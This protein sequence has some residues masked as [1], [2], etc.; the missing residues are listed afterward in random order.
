VKAF[1]DRSDTVRTDDRYIIHKCLNGDSAAFGILVDKYKASIYALAY[2]KLRN[3]HDAEDI[4]QEAFI[5]AYRNL[6]TLRYWDDFPAWLYSITSNLCKNWIRSQSTRPDR[7]FVADQ[8][9]DLLTRL[10]MNSY[11][12]GMTRESVHEA[13]N[14][15]PEIYRQV[16]TLYYFSGMS[17]REI[18]GFLRI[19]PNTIAQRLRRARARMK[20]EMIAMMSETFEE[21]KLQADFT[22]RIV[23]AVKRIK[24]QPTPRTAGLPWGLSLATGII[25]AVLSIGSNFSI[26]NPLRAFMDSVSTS[27]AADQGE[28][29]VDVLRLSQTPLSSGIPMDG[30]DGKAEFY[31]DQNA[32]LM[33]PRGEGDN[34]PEKPSGQLGKGRVFAVA[35]SPD[36]KTLAIA[37]DVGIWL[38]DAHNLD[39]IG[40]LEGPDW[41]I[42]IAF[43]PDGNVLASGSYDKTIRLWDVQKQ[44]ALGSLEGIEENAE[45]LAFSPDGNILASGGGR[46][47][48]EDERDMVIHLWDVAGKKQ[49]GLLQGHADVTWFLAFSP[50]GKLLA[51]D[52]GDGA[53]RLWNVDEQKQSGLLEGHTD[54][55]VSAGFSPDGKT[56][57]SAGADK[58]VRLWNVNEQKQSGLL[59]GHTDAVISVVFSP[60]GK[61]LASASLDRAIRLWDM[62]VQKQVGLLQGHTDEIRSIAFSPD[63]E[64]LASGSYGKTVLIWDIQSKKQTAELQGYTAGVSSFA[65]NPDGKLL[66]SGDYNFGGTVH[67]WD[68]QELKQ[69]GML[70]GHTEPIFCVAFSPDGKM[71]AS[72]SQDRTVRLWDAQGQEQ[73][74][75]LPGPTRP[76]D[77]VVFSPDGELLAAGCRDKNIYLWDV[78]TQ[79]QAGVLRGHGGPAW[80]VAFSPDGNLLASGGGIGGQDNTVRLWDVPG[81]KQVGILQ[82]HTDIVYSVAFSP[83]GKTLASGSVDKTVRLWDVQ[84]QKQTGLL[85]GH[86][87]TVFSVAFSPDGRFLASG[88]PEEAVRLWDVQKQEQ[89]AVLQGYIRPVAFSRDG[90]WLAT[91]GRGGTVQLWEVN[92]GGPGISVKPMGKLPGTWGEVKKMTLFQNFPNPFNPETWMPFSLSETERVVIRIYNPTGQLVRAL[93]LGQKPSGS[94]LSKEKAAHWDGRNERG[95]LVASDVYFYVMEAGE[96]AT[97]VRKMVMV[98]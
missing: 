78:S 26:S 29:P 49:I 83:D 70:E 87:E 69:V 17:I 1:T 80:S 50:D 67:L 10:S 82:G 96:S 36:E 63:G 33:A 57:A 11:R 64:T 41:V 56:L 32:A 39:E 81:Q 79:R 16:L 24:I 66:A 53:I 88:G 73:L 45:C 77:S 51:S 28:I 61:T 97:H 93:D 7:D 42:S 55:V 58:T 43:S 59:Q 52:G 20:Q 13:L 8:N 98:R 74:G 75:I 86:T 34:F 4:T 94:Y 21:Q 35:Y 72:G 68:V 91:Q 22:F 92:L 9:P 48:G 27:R 3:F 5:K 19:P 44:E 89:T 6:R 40:L 12:D 37:T 84:E 46:I 65:F 15:L 18:G 14:S 54:R 95:E 62:S 76:C 60:D 71:I 85:Q 38:H 25:I 31:D 2:S 47:I 23:E 30:D 90:K